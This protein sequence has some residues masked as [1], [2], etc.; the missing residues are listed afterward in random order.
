MTKLHS[1]ILGTPKH[2]RLAYCLH[3][4]GAWIMQDRFL[5][6]YLN[7]CLRIVEGR[8]D[9][10]KF[11]LMKE[12]VTNQV[13]AE[14]TRIILAKADDT[15][16][17]A[18]NTRLQDNHELHTL[19]FLS[20]WSAQEAGHENIAAAILGTIRPIAEEA[21]KKFKSPYKYNIAQWP[22]T[23]EACLEICKKLDQ[24]AKRPPPEGWDNMA[25]LNQF[26]DWL[27]LTLEVTSDI[28][29]IYNEASMIRNVI[30]HQYGKLNASD[31]VRA[32]HLQEWVGKTVPMT[33]D[34]LSD[35]HQ[36]IVSVYLAI[37][38]AIQLQKWI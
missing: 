4:T 11:L 24:K 38:K 37:L 13:S 29:A 1:V 14:N 30:T 20:E 10:H 35:Y 31:V 19:T 33:E 3:E 8:A 22:W 9:V 23:D 12:C 27:G 16:K 18:K 7:D 26:F 36:A 17:W 2:N 6:T 21:L 25:R 34:R 28:T 32:P 5:P 15:I